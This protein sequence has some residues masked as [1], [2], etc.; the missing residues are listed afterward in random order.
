MEEMSPIALAG[1]DNPA[2][3]GPG[4]G[5]DVETFEGKVPMVLSCNIGATELGLLRRLTR[6]RRGC[7]RSMVA[8]V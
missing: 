2:G 4:G 1:R 7:D 6:R 8:W 5:G 3:G